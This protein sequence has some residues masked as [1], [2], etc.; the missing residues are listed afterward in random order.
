MPAEPKRTI[1]DQL[2]A[3]AKQRRD[4]AGA[5]LEPHPVTRKLLQDEVARTFSARTI[6]K[7]TTP[8]SWLA[9][10]WVRLAF[11]G[12][13]VALLIGAAIFW[14][15]KDSGPG[16]GLTQNRVEPAQRSASPSDAPAGAGIGG[17]SPT[18]PEPFAA[19]ERQTRA[20]VTQR[21]GLI[22]QPAGEPNS[23]ARK[24][25]ADPAQPSLPPENQR[26]DTESLPK[27][28]LQQDGG[29]VTSAAAA[30]P[31]LE[32]RPSST[33]A[34]ASLESF[35]GAADK[36]SKLA[37]TPTVSASTARNE[38]EVEPLR[39]AEA[40]ALAPAAAGR[41]ET[42][43]SL[44][45]AAPATNVFFFSQ[46][47][48]RAKYRRNFNSP[49]IPPVLRSFQVQQSGANVRVLDA[50]GSVYEGVVEQPVMVPQPRFGEGASS[51]PKSLANNFVE[52]RARSVEIKARQQNLQPAGVGTANSVGNL[53]FRAAGTNQSLNQL[54][55][56]TGELQPDT[57]QTA[58]APNRGMT[59]GNAASQA[60]TLRGNATIGRNLGI[61]IEAS[62]TTR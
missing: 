7:R 62:G 3:F 61:P 14:L 36:V 29:K 52:Q 2:R 40:V 24:P 34:Q 50:D 13:L 25:D 19:N 42:R 21:Y 5:A 33:V 51:D 32:L 27:L 6:A 41:G 31:A 11:A 43:L 8:Q 4:V 48:T 30:A 46:A 9:A 12:G 35:P 59:Q 38:V 20:E 15:P 10:F 58:A 26:G 44:V 18:T 53:M 57:N 49:P 39:K 45:T 23:F 16:A 28:A 60:V 37:E 22:P 47:D 56:I 55:V 54:V 17:G 1:G